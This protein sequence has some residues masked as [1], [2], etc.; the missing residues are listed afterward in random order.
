MSKPDKELI[1]QVTFYS[2]GFR[3]APLL[4]SQIVPVFERCH[5]RLSK[6]AHYDFGLRA[7]KSVLTT[8]GNLKR[9]SISLEKNDFL[10]DH[11]WEAGLVVRSMRESI[12]PKLVDQDPE[13][14]ATILN[15]V[16]PQI[17]YVPTEFSQLSA[18]IH[19]I[20]ASKGLGSTDQWMTKIIQLHQIILVHHGIMMVGEAGSGKTQTW[21]LLSSALTQMDGIETI[22]YVI[23]AKTMSKEALYGK[24]D[25]T[26]R[27]W[28]DG[29]FT[30]IIRKITDNLRGEASKRHWIVF[31][32]D[33]DPEWVESMNR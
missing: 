25:F 12:M 3:Y 32:G 22:S 27:E 7:L 4:A 29:L 24:L 26:T 9:A 2:Q 13:I 17:E 23:D 5:E 19:Q 8:C 28:T 15:E 18:A 20:A 21:S 30:S 6:Q 11:A 33:V 16:F 10:V 14:L 1:A 31:D